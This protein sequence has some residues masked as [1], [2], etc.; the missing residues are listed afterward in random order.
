MNGINFLAIIVQLIFLCVY[1]FSTCTGRQTKLYQN[2]YYVRP[3][4]VLLP[5][6]LCPGQPCFDLAYYLQHSEQYFTSNTALI[7][8]EGVHKLTKSKYL[9]SNIPAVIHNVNNFA[10]IGSKSHATKPITVGTK[11]I[12]VVDPTTKVVCD[13]KE[14]SA[15]V[16]I[17]VTALTISD[18]E[19]TNCGQKFPPNIWNMA[20]EGLHK[21]FFPTDVFRPPAAILLSKIKDLEMKN[22]S[23]QNSTGY[24]LLGINVLGNSLIHNTVFLR[25][26]IMYDKNTG[27]A[28]DGGNCYFVFINSARVCEVSNTYKNFR[29]F[30]ITASQIL[31]GL[32]KGYPPSALG[33]NNYYN[34]KNK[35]YVE[36]FLSGGGLAIMMTPTDFKV[37][38]T[39]NDIVTACNSALFNAE[40]TNLWIVLHDK[41]NEAI[42]HIQN[43][44]GLLG[45]SS[46]SD[47][48]NSIGV[49]IAEFRD[50]G[51]DLTD[52]RVSLFIL[53]SQF[54]DNSVAVNFA[55]ITSIEPLITKIENCFFFNNEVHLRIALK[56]NSGPH[57]YLSKKGNDF[58]LT[59]KN[60]TFS[61][62]RVKQNWSLIPS[63]SLQS[64]HL[65]LFLDCQ[66]L[67][68][69]GTAIT[70]INSDIG[71]SGN[72][73]FRNNT[74]YNGGAIALLGDSYLRQWPLIGRK[75]KL[76]LYRNHAIHS[77]G[78]VY[79]RNE[80]EKQLVQIQELFC[81][82]SL[83]DLPSGQELMFFFEENTANV[84][85]SAIYGA[86][87]ENCDL[88]VSP[89]RNFDNVIKVIPS[90]K[91]DM[92]VIASDP[93][94]IVKCRNNNIINNNSS[95]EV[96]VQV[97]PGEFFTVELGATGRGG[98]LAPAAINST[99][100]NTNAS[101]G[102]LQH[103]QEVNSSCKNLTYSIFTN[104]VEYFEQLIIKVGDYANSFIGIEGNRHLTVNIYVKQCP[105]GFELPTNNQPS[106]TCASIFKSLKTNV[107]C[108]ISHQSFTRTGTVWIHGFPML[109]NL[110][111]HTGVVVHIQC[112]FDYC[113][114]SSITL[115]LSDP[116]KQCSYGRTGILCGACGHGLSLILG[117]L[118][119]AL[120]SSKYLVLIPT[121]AILGLLLVVLLTMLNLTVSVG[122]INGLIFFVNVVQFNHSTFFPPTNNSKI[123]PLYIILQFFVAWLNLDFGIPTCFYNSMNMYAY[124]WLEFVFPVY[125]WTIIGA[126]IL[127]S[128]RYV[129]LVKILSRNAIK[130]LATLF[131]LSYAK[132]IRTITTILSFTTIHY[133]NGEN[134]KRWIY[135]GNI[136]YAQGIHI[137]L[138]MTAL[139]FTTFFL[140]PYTLLLVL[141][142]CL[143]ANS[144]LFFLK[145]VNRIMPFLDAYQG[146]YKSRYRYWTGLMLVVRLI[147]F[148]TFAVSNGDIIVNLMS[149]SIVIVCLLAV[150]YFT[151]P[152]YKDK[153]VSTLELFFLLNLG[154]I[155]ISSLFASS[156]L[157]S[158]P[159]QIKITCTSVTCAFS[160]FICILIYHIY[161]KVKPKLFTYF[162]KKRIQEMQAAC[163][164]EEQ[165]TEMYE[166]N[167]GVPTETIVCLPLQTDMLT[168]PLLKEEATDS[169]TQN[170]ENVD[171]TTI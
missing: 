125:V 146:P 165:T 113:N 144:N 111:D 87:L 124:T 112:P 43:M 73:L 48:I 60:S 100:I 34:S 8:T 114:Q 61:Q 166:E 143:H 16:F 63:I 150:N 90:S 110:T 138:L 164:N 156:R 101:L 162:E 126:L 152:L 129:I 142:P 94:H 25:N 26:K 42:I 22:V 66:F 116:D 62:S 11:N 12:T 170:S 171:S 64:V 56:R 131:L 168:E 78:A 161:L 9:I 115:T 31:L 69:L 6:S 127:L 145:W 39:L 51:C 163:R 38:I 49:T 45:S 70:A 37:K 154:I 27:D 41:I 33:N 109:Y 96:Q 91:S 107:T 30:R 59:V 32:G 81:S 52:K 2:E 21:A 13:P 134:E 75:N 86:L 136:V 4:T 155:S 44:T 80:N 148:V 29:N 106:C 71:T 58:I 99:L 18:I 137:P 17:D 3:S 102:V 7:F 139:A 46:P 47:L 117:D 89:I 128:R 35:H 104:K 149:T 92:S 135:D 83:P 141:T 122:A 98:G 28:S 97:Y 54:M 88:G 95:L 105:S 140:A 24:G 132:L 76:T 153:I 120:C 157:D 118:R 36:M 65:V 85:G 5:F 50:A 121:F 1:L 20:M 108:D 151:G 82:F 160:V 68:N 103:I 67:D 19:F 55:Q 169:S 93:T 123:K 167:V 84:C 14:S 74:G 23:I 79:V 40:G 130:V 15:L 72:N 119:C 77:G 147:L 159:K 10:L 53:D 133:P 57:V 158:T